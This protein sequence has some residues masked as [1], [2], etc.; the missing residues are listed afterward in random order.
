MIYKADWFCNVSKSSVQQIA[1][2]L[3]FDAPGDKKN[4]LFFSP[5]LLNFKKKKIIYADN[6]VQNTCSAT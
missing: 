2:S 6:F 5:L 4:K 3:Y 1:A